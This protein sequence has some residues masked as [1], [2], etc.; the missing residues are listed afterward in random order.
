M[1]SREVTETDI[2]RACIILSIIGLGLI[3]LSQMYM[4]PEKVSI[5]E[6][7]ETWIGRTVEITGS[8]NVESKTGSAAFLNIQDSTGSIPAVD[9]EDR[10]YPDQ[11]SATGYI[12]M[13]EGRLQ[14]V[15]E[16]I[17]AE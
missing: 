8:I 6:I 9:F 17:S 10:E 5:D 11:A 16:N 13:Y 15:I 3:H 2:Y 14:I 12:D 4:E 7:D 1:I